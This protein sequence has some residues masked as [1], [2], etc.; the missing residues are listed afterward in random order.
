MD[1]HFLDDSMVDAIMG[2]N[3][4]DALESAFKNWPEAIDIV[5]IE[6]I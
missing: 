5:P 4:A 6:G 1:I 3:E 2:A